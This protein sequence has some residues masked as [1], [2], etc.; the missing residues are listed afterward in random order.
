MHSFVV[1]FTLFELCSIFSELTLKI[2]DR[3]L[4][5]FHYERSNKT[6]IGENMQCCY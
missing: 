3:K 4:I 2:I 6:Q 5:L 1:I